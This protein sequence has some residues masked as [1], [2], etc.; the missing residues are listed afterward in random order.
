M[1]TLPTGPFELACLALRRDGAV[2]LVPPAEKYA[3]PALARRL[4]ETQQPAR[5]EEAQR[6]LGQQCELR[7]LPPQRCRAVA[8]LLQRDQILLVGL[9]EGRRLR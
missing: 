8:Q 6:V 3:P 7:R 2:L 9:G 5:L 4:G 1:H